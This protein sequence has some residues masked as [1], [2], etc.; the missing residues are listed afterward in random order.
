LSDIYRLEHGTTPLVVSVPHA[1]TIVPAAIAG[2]LTAA[3]RALPDTDWHVDRLYGFA[4]GLGASL[5]VATHSRYVIDVNRPPD[6]APLYR[7]RRVTG[8]CPVTTFDGEPIYLEGEA[9]EAAEVGDRRARFW[10]PYHACLRRELEVVRRRFGV[11]LLFDAHSIRSEIPS[12]FPGRLPELNLG[13]GGGSSAGT[14]LTT[15]IAAVLAATEAYSSVVNGWFK[16]G[17]ITREYGN[18]SGGVHAVQLELAQRGYMREGP[19]AEPDA[20]RARRLEP[21]L[22][23]VLGAM[24][25]WAGGVRTYDS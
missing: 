14:E 10:E 9:P 19:P 20:D 23:M 11:A 12:L 3:G 6:D 2:R 25:E 15:R 7:G 16:G 18:P 21:V 22:S 1:G 17:H 5:L 13:T 8:L 24:L 4:R